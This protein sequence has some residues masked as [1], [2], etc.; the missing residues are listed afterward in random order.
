VTRVLD[1]LD[2][3]VFGD[4]IDDEAGPRRL[5]RLMVRAVDA[6]AVSS[7]DAAEECAGD[8]PDG[9]PRLVAWVCLAVREAIRNLVRDVLDQ[10]PT[11]RNI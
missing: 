8:H 6:E 1:A 3:A 10:G 4:G 2:N 11:K 5:D 7:G 9:V